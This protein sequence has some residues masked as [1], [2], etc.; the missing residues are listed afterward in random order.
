MKKTVLLKLF[1][2]LAWTRRNLTDSEI[3]CSEI[4]KGPL[5]T[6][7]SGAKG[8]SLQLIGKH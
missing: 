6:E 3:D 2:V 8:N 7:W 4:I 5:S 1:W